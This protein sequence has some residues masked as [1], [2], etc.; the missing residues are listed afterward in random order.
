MN[1]HIGT[2]HAGF[3]L[4]NK[5]VE[6]L[7]ELGHTITDHGAFIYDANDDYPDFIT[8]VAH[9]VSMDTNSFGIILGGSGQG[10]AMNA[11]RFA[12][13]RAIEYY[14]GEIEIVKLG[15][16]HNNANVLSLGARFITDE[17]AREAV[18]VFIETEFSRDERHIRRI[19]K[20]NKSK[21]LT[22]IKK[23]SIIWGIITGIISLLFLLASGFELIVKA[24]SDLSWILAIFYWLAAPIVSVIFLIFFILLFIFWIKRD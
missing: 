14:G 9:A 11:N 13:V 15:R 23:V 17:E 2:D 18:K 10:E 20:M 19:R 21:K 16:E 7:N 4:K 8:P 3:E 24:D 22:I 6:Y 1:I 5:L 12:E